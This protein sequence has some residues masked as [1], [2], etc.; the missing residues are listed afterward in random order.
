MSIENIHAKA[1]RPIQHT[2][3]TEKR[4]AKLNDIIINIVK[5]FDLS[6]MYEVKSVV[7][8]GKF[9]LVGVHDIIRETRIIESGFI[10]AVRAVNSGAC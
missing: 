2:E 1:Y 3:S 8:A 4:K 10:G 9:K 5:T 7:K 6:R